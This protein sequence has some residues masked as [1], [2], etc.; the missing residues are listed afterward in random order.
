MV[1]RGADD[2]QGA[3][4]PALALDILVQDTTDLNR[5]TEGNLVVFFATACEYCQKSV[6][7]YKALSKRCD[8]TLTFAFTDPEGSTITDWW[9]DHQEGFSEECSPVSI[10]RLLAHPSRYQVRVTPTHY[11]VGSDR[12]VKHRHEGMLPEVPERLGR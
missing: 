8:L 10:G 7:T 5:G 1:S 6:P 12:R 4:F 2:W 9:Q 11:L 3:E